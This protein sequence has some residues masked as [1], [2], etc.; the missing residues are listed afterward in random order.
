MTRVYYVE[1]ENGEQLAQVV[2]ETIVK[3]MARNC[4]VIDVAYQSE[5]LYSA[6]LTLSIPQ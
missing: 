1:A 3:F 6:L 2:N 5:P 4:N